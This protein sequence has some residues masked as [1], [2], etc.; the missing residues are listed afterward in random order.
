[1]KGSQITVLIN[2]NAK[3]TDLDNYVTA[4]LTSSAEDDKSMWSGDDSRMVWLLASKD[5]FAIPSCFLK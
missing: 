1:M 2:S 4:V 3:T 5:R